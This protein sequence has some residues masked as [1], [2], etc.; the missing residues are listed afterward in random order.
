MPEALDARALEQ[1]FLNARTFNKFSDR[2]IDDATVRQLYE[3]AKWGPTAMNAQPMRL[4][5]VRSAEAKALLKPALSPG[6]VDKTL[7]APLTAIVAF[8]SRFHE[9][10]VTQFPA[11]P[12]AGAG[13]AA[14]AAKAEQNARL[15][16]SLQAGYLIVA[17]RM[18]GLDAGPMGGF[19]PAKVNEAFFP[20]GRWKA[21]ILV[22]LGYGDPSGNRPRGPRLAFEEAVR[23]V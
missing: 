3:L 11:V 6:N 7:A 9:H 12:N 15:N 2:P 17:A 22:N 14:D 23:I 19:D 20:D 5:F 18:L 8:D 21:N 1:I 4:V 13:F 16:G 10:L